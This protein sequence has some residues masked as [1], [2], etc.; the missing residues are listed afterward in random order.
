M[1]A[2]AHTLDER[3]GEGVGGKA[4]REKNK[5]KEC[6]T[7]LGIRISPLARERENAE[8]LA[9]LTRERISSR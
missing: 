2:H 8:G 4:D 5:G 3:D 9:R 6:H 1:R 7:N